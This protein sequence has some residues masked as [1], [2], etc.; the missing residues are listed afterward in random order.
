MWESCG[1]KGEGLSHT[2][3]A[4]GREQLRRPSGEQSF[5]KGGGNRGGEKD[6]G[7][8]HWRGPGGNGLA[9]REPR[10][11]FYIKAKDNINY[12]PLHRRASSAR[13]TSIDAWE[14]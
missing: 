7:P 4:P 14:Q 9:T 8:G 13:H 5:V 11:A 10:Q 12:Y 1:L 3:L 2:L 6:Y